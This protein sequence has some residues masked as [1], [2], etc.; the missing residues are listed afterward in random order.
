MLVMVMA[1]EQVATRC[2]TPVDTDG[3][4]VK[5]Q[6]E[7]IATE[8]W[9]HGLNFNTIHSTVNRPNK[10]LLR[11]GPPHRHTATVAI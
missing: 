1:V 3:D 7:Y 10:R 6:K 4:D 8:S 11:K 2:Q 9:Y 5:C